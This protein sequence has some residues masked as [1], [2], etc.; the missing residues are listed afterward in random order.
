MASTD[1]HKLGKED[2]NFILP[3]R[4]FGQGHSEEPTFLAKAVPLGRSGYPRDVAEGALY[5]ASDAG[6]FVTSHDLIIDAGRSS[7]FYEPNA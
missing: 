5:L 6:K 7:M 3:E 2:G 4:T 1:S